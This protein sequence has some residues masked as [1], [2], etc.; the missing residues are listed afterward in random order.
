[1][2]LSVLLLTEF[3]KWLAE[4]PPQ[5]MLLS[6]PPT[7][8]L[9]FH[10]L[11][12]SSPISVLLTALYLVFWGGKQSQNHVTLRPVA[13]LQLRSFLAHCNSGAAKNSWAVTQLW[14]HSTPGSSSC[15]NSACKASASQEAQAAH[16][17]AAAP[18]AILEVLHKTT[19][20]LENISLPS[21]AAALTTRKS[22][23]VVSLY[24]AVPADLCYF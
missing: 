12:I 6:P 3:C 1:M 4:D 9:Q 17:V 5:N 23:A 18:S 21:P 19:S 24:S 13:T 10:H 7:L 8:S 16:H 2:Q 15:P 14:S 11:P 22:E 20:T